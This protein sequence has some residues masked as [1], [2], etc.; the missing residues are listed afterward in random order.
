[1]TTSRDFLYHPVTKINLSF[2]EKELIPRLPFIEKWGLKH[3]ILAIK[4]C[5]FLGNNKKN[6]FT[7]FIYIMF[8]ISNPFYTY[9]RIKKLTWHNKDCRKT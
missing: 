3:E 1:M 2:K 5:F 8:N 9:L 7:R 6:P 4:T